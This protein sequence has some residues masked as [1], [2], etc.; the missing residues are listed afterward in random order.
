MT[1]PVSGIMPI[2]SLYEKVILLRIAETSYAANFFSIWEGNSE[3][4]KR[5]DRTYGISS[6]Y[7]KV[8]L[9]NSNVRERSLYF[10]SIWEGNS[11]DKW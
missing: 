6:L 9:H 10:F 4:E 1:A 5:P 8:I 2:S 7:E 11:G 3:K